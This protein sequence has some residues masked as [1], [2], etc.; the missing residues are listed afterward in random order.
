MKAKGPQPK[1]E[2]APKKEKKPLK[3]TAVKKSPAGDARTDHWFSIMIRLRDANEEGYCRCIVSGEWVHWLDCDAGHFI[4]RR[5]KATKYHEQ[6]VHAQKRC[7]NRFKAGEQF[8]YG[9]NLDKIYKPGTAAR[10]H[11]LSLQYKKFEKWE[12]QAMAKHFQNTAEAY[13]KEKRLPI[14]DKM[15]RLHEIH[16][17]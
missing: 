3:R 7:S 15:Y 14:P 13:S 17:K 8:L 6:N 1:P 4:S 10:L 2:P 16:A 11:A 9:Q 12:L 5:H